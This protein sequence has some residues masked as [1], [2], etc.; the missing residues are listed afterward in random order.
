MLKTTNLFQIIV[1]IFIILVISSCAT[2]KASKVMDVT[3]STQ[4]S[5]KSTVKFNRP[6][7]LIVIPVVIN[8]KSYNFLWD[9][10]AISVIS[11]DLKNELNLKKKFSSGVKDSAGKSN[12]LEYVQVPQIT[13]SGIEFNNV[14]VAV[15]NAVKSKTLSCLNIE[16][17]V[18]GNLMKAAIWEL[19]LNDNELNFASHIDSFDIK[20]NSFPVGFKIGNFG[21]PYVDLFVDTNKF[22]KLTF[23]SGYSG[24]VS[25]S[26]SNFKDTSFTSIATKHLGYN[27]SGLYG[28]NHSLQYS[29]PMRASIDSLHGNTDVVSISNTKKKKLVGVEFMEGYDLIINWNTKMIHLTPLPI[30]Q[31]ALSYRTIIPKY[32][33]NKLVLGTIE[34]NSN[35]QNLKISD[36]IDFLN[37]KN[38]Q[39]FT[40]Q[41]YCHFI[42]NVEDTPDSLLIELE[43][44]KQVW[45]TKKSFD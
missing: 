21:T 44:G 2:W 41:D 31:K 18:G 34:M 35:T 7:K 20:E 28:Q 22:S 39:D 3:Y 33:E 27:S 45:S 6:L 43:N 30:E 1:S 13:I 10:G 26:K 9:T 23:D 16:G 17:I 14:G 42:N 11:E 15:T 8:G 12:K 19:K 38:T 40:I 24:F 4:K 36:K 5:F 37:G 29:I 32:L 25:I